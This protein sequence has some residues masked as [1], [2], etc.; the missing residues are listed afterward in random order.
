[1][2]NPGNL[3]NRANLA[4][5]SN[6]SNLSNLANLANLSNL[7]NL[8][9]LSN[10]SNLS[11]LENRYKPIANARSAEASRYRSSSL[12]SWCVAVSVPKRPCISSNGPA[13]K[14]SVSVGPAFAPFPNARPQSP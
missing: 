11:N 10:L 9:N 5:L 8:A 2:E 1:V 4:N 12:S 3:A 7:S 13:V 14:K 6:L